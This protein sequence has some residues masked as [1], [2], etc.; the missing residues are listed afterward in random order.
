MKRYDAVALGEILIDFVPSGKDSDGDVRYTR[1]AGGAPLNLLAVISRYGGNTA[2]IGKVGDDSFGRFLADTLRESGVDGTGLT[3]D[4]THNTTLAFVTLSDDGDRDF[5]F[6]RNYGA[7]VCLSERDVNADLIREAKIF[8]F[9]SL[10][11][12]ASPSSEATRYALKIAKESSC[13]VSY[14]PNWRAPLWR[15]PNVAVARMREHLSFADI[16][17]VSREEAEMITE[18]RDSTAQLAALRAFGVRVVLITDGGNGVHFSL[19]GQ[20]GFLPSLPVKAIDTTG[21]GD[22]FFGTF[23]SCF[24]K[25]GADFDSL[26]FADG[27]KYVRKAIEISGKSTLK[28]GAIASIPDWEE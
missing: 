1:K 11:C 12:T 20:D 25:A 16:V 18:E 5:S 8:H 21:A 4:E 3:I 23:L 19:C 10:S 27:E 17:K 22:I 14:D 24:L 2:F 6:Y 13:V 26:T 28:H 7:D 9:G 15:D